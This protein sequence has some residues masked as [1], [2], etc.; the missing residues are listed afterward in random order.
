MTYL[1]VGVAAYLF[2]AVTWVFYLAVMNLRRNKANM[3]PMVL[4]CFGYPMLWIGLVLDLV[5]NIIFGTLLLLQ[6][7]AQLLMTSRLNQ[8]LNDKYTDWRDR[9]SNWFARN[10]LDPFTLDGKPHV[11]RPQ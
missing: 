3:T 8:T 6:L 10:F 9:N 1:Y 11:K 2:I 4:Y 7:P 5:F